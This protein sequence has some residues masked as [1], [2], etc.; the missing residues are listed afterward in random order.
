[1]NSVNQ[2][3]RRRRVAD[4][5]SAATK[6]RIM[7]AATAEFAAHGLAGAR[8]DRIATAATTNKA[9]LYHYFGNKDALFDLVFDSFVQA[10]LNAVP[11][12]AERLPEWGADIYD[13]YVAN[14]A[15]V[16]LASWARLERTPAGDL[17]MR[18]G[19]I[20]PAV[21]MRI[22]GAQ[23]AGILIDTIAALDIFCLTVAIAATW[24]QAA[25]NITATQDDPPEEHERR[26]QAVAE[27]IRR[28]FCR[29]GH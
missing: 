11:L 15:L 20:D 26:R 23:A 25:I 1:M 29:P 24:S 10:N 8:V 5:D 18:W 28:A 13:Y 27:T 6:A 9:Q 21:V 17:F 19:G 14:P 4:R 7:A 3:V 2:L 22:T 12:D 16:R